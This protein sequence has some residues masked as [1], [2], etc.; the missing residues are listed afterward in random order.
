MFK[1][2]WFLLVFFQVAQSRAGGLPEVT[3]P[4]SASI[5]YRSIERGHVDMT[6]NLIPLTSITKF[7]CQRDD[8]YRQIHVI[9]FSPSKRNSQN[10]KDNAPFFP[11]VFSDFLAA[12]FGLGEEARNTIANLRVPSTFNKEQVPSERELATVFLLPGLGSQP[13][14]YLLTAAHLASF[15]YRVLVVGHTG[16]SGD[17]YSSSGCMIPGI[18]LK[19][20][21]KKS[22]SIFEIDQ[23]VNES[24]PIIISDIKKIIISEKKKN[25]YFIGHSIGAMAATKFCNESAHFCKGIVNLDGGDYSHHSEQSW[26]ASKKLPYLKFVSTSNVA[27]NDIPENKIG[28]MQWLIKF[29]NPL[30]VVEHQ[31]FTDIIFFIH[32]PKNGI[33][34]FKLRKLINNKIIKF[35][36]D[37]IRPI[38]T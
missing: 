22:Q 13:Q 11:G 36:K 12:S 2:V 27:V 32:Q 29:S 19:I 15:G 25:Y 17:M 30:E 7:H 4:Y 23:T 24:V 34:P 37:T 31:S 10:G 16:V 28:R 14:F 38:D 21:Q 26:P 33:D 1:W 3:G 8:Y 18:D 35:I 5:S 6:A 9:E 20:L